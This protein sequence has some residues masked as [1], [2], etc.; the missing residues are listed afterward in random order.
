MKKVLLF[1]AIIVVSVSCKNEEMEQQVQSL[2]NENQEL[3][4]ELAQKDST[5]NMFDESFAEIQRNL[6]L[7][8]ER[9]ESIR[10]NQG[11]LQNGTAAR[12]Q[13]TQDIQ[14][15]NSL[16]AENKETIANLNKSLSKYG[17]EVAGFK[18]LVGQLNKNIETKEQE[19]SMLKENLTAANFTIDIL[20]SMLDSTEY[21]NEMQA[22]L[23]TNQKDSINT[24]YYAIGTFKE[25][26][27]RGVVEKRGAIIGIA[28]SKELKDDFNKEY[29]ISIDM[30]KT[31][32]IPL[33]SESAKLITTHPTN[34]Y[35]IE[36]DEAKVLKIK[37]PKEFWS[38]S[39]YLVVLTD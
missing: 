39:R 1:A 16:L 26:E 37:S 14:A 24:A 13:I 33:N 8:G 11:D 12:E 30:R 9:E 34:S 27:E 22:Q 21:Q 4:N 23:L 32:S 6:A 38:T 31:Q 10:I 7:I 3:R 29:F 15:I 18:K 17:S 19:I 35:S 5:L 25:L 28:G 36:G 2:Q 20:N